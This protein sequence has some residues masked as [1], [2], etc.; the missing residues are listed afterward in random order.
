[1]AVIASGRGTRKTAVPFGPFMILGTFVGLL[2][3]GA[4]AGWYLRLIGG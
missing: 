3:G 4:V 1:V 2:A